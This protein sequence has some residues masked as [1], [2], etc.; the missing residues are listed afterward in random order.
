MRAMGRANREKSDIGRAEDALEDLKVDWED[1]E[2]KFERDVEE[3]EEK[4]NVDDLELEELVIRP[5]KGDLDVE[6]FVVIWLPYRV[7]SSGIAE[8]AF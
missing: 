8:P 7:D 4:M 5:R 6:K 3:I 1:M 2:E